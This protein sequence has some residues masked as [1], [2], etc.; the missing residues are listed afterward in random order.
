MVTQVQ[1]MT[2]KME[3]NEWTLKYGVLQ[4]FNLTCLLSALSFGDYLHSHIFNYH[5]CGED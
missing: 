5:H 1:V 2:E 3:R 4:D